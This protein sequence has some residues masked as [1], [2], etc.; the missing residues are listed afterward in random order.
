MAFTLTRAHSILLNEISD[1]YIGLSTTEPDNEGGNVTEPP[2]SSGY[3]RSFFDVADRDSSIKAQVANK[4]ILFFNESLEG[5]YGTVGWFVLY[6]SKT[7]QT[8]FFTGAL[9]TPMT[10]PA[11]YVPIF[12][13]H[14]L[15]IGLD[16]EVLEEY[17]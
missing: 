14:Q 2:E 5:G 3:E 4:K 11:G 13:A 17:A 7:S 1:V 15:V 6:E 10:I 9:N 12:R 8:P 16:K